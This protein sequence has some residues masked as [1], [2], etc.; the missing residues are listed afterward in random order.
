MSVSAL[1]AASEGG[2]D[3]RPAPAGAAPLDAPFALRHNTPVHTP[4]RVPS[5]D[6][7]EGGGDAGAWSHLLLLEVRLPLPR[8]A[9]RAACWAGGRRPG[10][11]DPTVFL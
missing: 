6:A 8:A 10:W 7:A 3:A 5:P 1:S 2:P 4:A 9:A 11:P